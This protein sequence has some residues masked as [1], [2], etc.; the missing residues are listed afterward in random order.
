M[1]EGR[2]KSDLLIQIENARNNYLLGLAAMSLLMSSSA[3]EHLR[4]SHAS[5]D[6]YIVPFDQVAALLESESDKQIA[7]KE[8]FKMLL[9]ALIKESY[10]LIL[11]Y[12]KATKQKDHFRSQQWYHFARLIRNC[13]S[14]DFH[15]RFEPADLK[16]LP[17]TW[18]G[19]TIEASM[20]S[21]P[22]PIS[23]LGYGGAWE[24]FA[25]LEQFAASSW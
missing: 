4:I 14:H 25:E 21:K 2:L 13:V 15:F 9:R 3:S 20:H 11:G 19:R 23:F 16:V 8:F 12:A 22:L 7:L 6:G 18:N 5:F 17:A 24:L 10:E 1:V